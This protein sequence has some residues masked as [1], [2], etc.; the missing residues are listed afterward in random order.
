MTRTGAIGGES[1]GEGLVP[2]RSSGSVGSAG[3]SAFPRL[4]KDTSGAAGRA[5]VES[6]G[7]GFDVLAG[8]AAVAAS[9]D[10]IGG[11]PETDVDGTTR[12]ASRCPHS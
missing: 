10:V 1:A 8:A 3:M 2:L 6:A 11:A 5:F 4:L 9:G 12:C 7:A